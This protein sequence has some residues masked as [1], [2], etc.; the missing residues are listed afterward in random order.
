VKKFCLLAAPPLRI[1][2]WGG[3][4]SQLN[5][6]SFAIDFASRFPKRRLVLVFHTDGVTRRDLE[7]NDIIPEFISSEILDDFTPKEFV[8]NSRTKTRKLFSEFF[9]YLGIVVFSSNN[10]IFSKIKPWTLA[11]RSHYSH[12]NF[13][14]D[15]LDYL[16]KSLGLLNLDLPRHNLVL[17]YRLGDLLQLESI[18]DITR[19]FSQ[20]DWLI[21]TDSPSEARKLL[22]HISSGA[23]LGKF[24]KVNPEKV[25][26]FGVASETFIGTTSKLS[27][28][29]AI[30]R[31]LDGNGITYMPNSMRAEM[32]HF[33]TRE[34]SSRIKFFPETS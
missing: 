3:Y 16:A 4:G 8:V 13:S 34:N 12:V 21:L 14:G 23:K 30:F 19:K 1:H 15:A 22:E 20:D 11:V 9:S 33:I 6:L 26:Q 10:E 5:A 7:I 27:I 32:L 17:H 2:C 24:L 31:T 18:L 25:I 29:I 28:W